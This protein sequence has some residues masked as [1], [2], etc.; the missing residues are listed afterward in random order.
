MIRESGDRFSDGIM[1][2]PQ[3][4]ARW[5]F[6]PSRSRRGHRTQGRGPRPRG[7]GTHR[8][9]RPCFDRCRI[10]GDNYSSSIELFTTSIFRSPAN[11]DHRAIATRSL[12]AIE[13]NR[14][15]Q[16]WSIRRPRGASR[17]PPTCSAGGRRSEHSEQSWRPAIPRRG[18]SRHLDPRSKE[19]DT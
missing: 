5:R 2:K 18:R 1:R 4:G 8:V 7:R 12:V 9:L 6:E 14:W 10:I 11:R 15:R 13:K 17:D 16:A 3:T 19:Q